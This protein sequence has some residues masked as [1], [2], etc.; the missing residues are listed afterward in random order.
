MQFS[1]K[2]AP[3]EIGRKKKIEELSRQIASEKALLQKDQAQAKKN[4]KDR[5]RK[6]YELRNKNKKDLFEFGSQE[7]ENRFVAKPGTSEDA[8]NTRSDKRP[9]N[10]PLTS[11][12]NKVVKKNKNLIT[13]EEKV[14]TRS[15]SK[16]LLENEKKQAEAQAPRRSSR[17][18]NKKSPK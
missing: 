18:Q 3:S 1:K 8:L 12:Q 9:A 17:I 16:K 13:R 4:L 14:I 11:P 15:L 7:Y 5:S 10:S 6:F 2:E